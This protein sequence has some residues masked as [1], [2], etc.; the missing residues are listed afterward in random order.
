PFTSRFIAQKDEYN[1][2]FTCEHCMYFDELRD[3]CLHEYPNH[4]HLLAT[5]TVKNNPSHIIFCKQFELR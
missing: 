2:H 3:Q 1:F 4:M 5:Y